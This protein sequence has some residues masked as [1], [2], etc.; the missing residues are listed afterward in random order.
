MRKVNVLP[1]DTYFITNKAIL[2]DYDRKIIT[3]LYQPIIG[4]IAVNLYFTFWS[5]YENN[6]L[7]ERNHYQ[8]MTSMQL[9][10]ETI[11]LAREKLEGIGLL[12]TYYKKSSINNFVY[13]IYK[14]L[15]AYEFFT[16]PLLNTLLMNNVGKEQYETIVNEFKKDYFDLTGYDNITCSFNEIFKMTSN[17]VYTN[18][19][20]DIHITLK[21]RLLQLILTLILLW[22]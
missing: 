5:L 19:E 9:K 7:L 14:P 21:I 11:V 3:L 10:L 1:A 12:K 17:D 18:I 20:T 8:L 13:E 16:S 15:N 6:K 22:I 4:S 2:T